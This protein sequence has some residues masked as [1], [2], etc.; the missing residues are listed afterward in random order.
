MHLVVA[1]TPHGYGHAAQVAPVLNVLRSKIDALQLTVLSTVPESFFRSRIEGDFRFIAHAADFGLEMKSS[2]AIDHDASAL[3]YQR[4]H[5]SWATHVDEEYEFLARLQPDCILADVPYLT[6]AAAEKLCVPVFALCSLNWADIYR[7]YYYVRPE[8]EKIMAEMAEAYQHADIFYC[9]E[10]SMPMTWLD[11]KFQVGPIASIGTDR[12]EELL[13]TLQL[14]DS[15][16]LVVVA[17]GG[18]ATRFPLEN[19]P[20][21]SGVTWLVKNDPAS[22]HPDVFELDAV[23]MSFTDV[24]TSVDVLLGKCGYGTVAECV[25]NGT[26][27]LYIPRPDWPEESCLLDWMKLHNACL[28]ISEKNIISGNMLEQIHE[29]AALDVDTVEATGAVDAATSI[30]A[31]LSKAEA[32]KAGPRHE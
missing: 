8:A 2:L 16:R 21:N 23:S 7:H 24:L 4:L 27:M 20:R 31:V 10:P 22:D 9:P 26:P 1:I 32:R 19:W 30:C 5:E 14:P 25:V 18:L 15:Q 3:A 13:R 29:C 28:P 12:R 11:N 6:L 17:P